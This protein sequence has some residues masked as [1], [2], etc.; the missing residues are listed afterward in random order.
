MTAQVL[1]LSSAQ[2]I[3]NTVEVREI[4]IEILSI[5][6]ENDRRWYSN[7]AYI[8]AV[9][10]LLSVR[11]SVLDSKFVMDANYKSLLSAF[12][13]ALI[14]QAT[15]MRKRVI[16]LHS[17]SIYC[18]IESDMETI[19]KCFLGYKYSS[20][21]PVQTMR[22]KKIW[23]ILNGSYDEFMP[24]YYNGACSFSISNNEKPESINQ[25]L[26]LDDCLD[27]WNENLDKEMTKD[28]HL[29]Y[30]FHTLFTDMDFSIFDLLWVRDFNIEITTEV[31]YD[32]YPKDVEKYDDID[33]DKCDYFD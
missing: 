7:N 18:G 12:N 17:A 31:D 4:E 19:G 30:P 24:L 14:A 21:H 6:E 23:N 28:M 8:E 10:H 32:T 33:W 13:E 5:I 1:R 3:F 15:E 22:A 29:V 2:E 9:K 16:D 26:Y 20:I 11:K 27:N 25:M